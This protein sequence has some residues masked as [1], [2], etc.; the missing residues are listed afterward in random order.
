MDNSADRHDQDESGGQNSWL[1]VLHSEFGLNLRNRIAD[2]LVQQQFEEDL[3]LAVRAFLES[4]AKEIAA[5]RLLSKCWEIEVRDADE[6]VRKAKQRNDLEDEIEAQAARIAKNKERK[7]LDDMKR[8]REESE[9]W[10]SI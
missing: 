7:R 10:P 3:H 1:P 8:R 6:I 9:K 4:G 2:P 5:S